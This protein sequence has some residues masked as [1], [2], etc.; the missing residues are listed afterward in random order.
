MTVRKLINELIRFEPNQEVEICC[1]TS[2]N[3][4]DEM[5]IYDGMVDKNGNNMCQIRKDIIHVGLETDGETVC[6]S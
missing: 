5:T 6:I 2:V 1:Y 4:P 3:N